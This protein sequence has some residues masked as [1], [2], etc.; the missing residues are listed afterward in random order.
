MPQ[1]AWGEDIH[2]GR[3]DLLSTDEL[4]MG[5]RERIKRAAALSTRGL[6]GKVFPPSPGGET[7]MTVMDMGSA[8][9]STARTAAKEH[10]CNVS[11]P[12]LT[13]LPT[14]MDDWDAWKI[15]FN[16]ETDFL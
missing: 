5:P 12:P 16:T 1:Q 3:Y 11:S 14:V 4:K 9:G 13:L 10:G 8:H 6:L 15:P 2:I 7:T